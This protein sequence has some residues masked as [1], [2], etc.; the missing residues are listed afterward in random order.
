[1][2]NIRCECGKII[3]Q[4]EKGYLVIKCRHCKRLVFMILDGEKRD[5]LLKQQFIHNHYDELPYP[6][7]K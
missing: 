1:M 7:V 4:R 2:A 5:Q 3:C 6:S